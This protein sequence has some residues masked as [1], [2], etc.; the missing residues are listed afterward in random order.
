MEVLLVVNTISIALYSLNEFYYY[1]ELIIKNTF[2]L[3]VGKLYKIDIYR[4]NK[5]VVYLNTTYSKVT[6]RT[7]IGN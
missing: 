5:V 3:S 7:F 6:K 4:Y 2:L 1:Y